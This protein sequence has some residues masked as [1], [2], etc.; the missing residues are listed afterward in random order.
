MSTS[1]SLRSM[2]SEWLSRA[3]VQLAKGAL[4]RQ[5][6]TNQLEQFY[7]LLEQV[8]I[9]GDT[10]GLD[11]LLDNWAASLTQTD[12]EGSLA[13]LTTILK[14][15]FV[16]TTQTSQETLEPTLA[17]DLLAGLALVFAHAFEQAA[18]VEIEARILYLTHRLAEVQSNLQKLD[19][20]KSDFIAVAAHELRTPLTL[21]EGYTAMLQENFQQSDPYYEM[22]MGIQNGANRLRVIIDDMI[23]VSLIDNNLLQLNFQP[24]WLNRIFNGLAL[25]LS[26]TLQDRNQQLTIH[27]FDGSNELIYA[28]PERVYQL[29]RNL[30]LN[31]IKFTPDSGKITITGRKLPGFIEVILKDTGIGI[32]PEDQTMLFAKFVRLD[33]SLQHSSGKTKFKGGGP[34]LGLHIARGIIEAHEGAIWAES[35]GRD[36][37]TC[38][39]S[40][41]H[42]L[43]PIRSQPPD[44]KTALLFSQLHHPI[45]S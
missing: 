6:L 12:L 30:L 26:S 45:S 5:D 19:R 2:R 22:A 25:E 42:I 15:L 17:L 11:T 21:V 40:T 33:N 3:V 31:A 41:F 16:V 24:L 9:T 27:P 18:R 43:L 36:E 13:S 14:E 39:G 10:S 8:L 20:T 28:D 23:D 37:Q 32:S 34:G 35:P 7:D 1:D 38:P 4:L 44:N 29:F